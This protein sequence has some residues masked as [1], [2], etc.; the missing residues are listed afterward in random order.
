MT[1]RSPVPF[2]VVVLLTKFSG[3]EYAGLTIFLIAVITDFFDGYFA[4]K[5]N[6]VTRLGALLDRR[7]LTLQLIGEF[8][9]VRT[10]PTPLLDRRLTVFLGLC[11]K[12][13]GIVHRRC[14]H[15]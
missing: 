3:R 2:L 8:E 15:T 9:E 5:Y 13:P 4:R 12:A 1:G 6:K 14:S 7:C 10:T 11:A